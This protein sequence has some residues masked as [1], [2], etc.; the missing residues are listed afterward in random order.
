MRPRGW[1]VWTSLSAAIGACGVRTALH[2]PTDG[3]DGGGWVCPVP[4]AALPLVGAR[5]AVADVDVP[6]P[7]IPNGGY[8]TAEANRQCRQWGWSLFHRGYGLMGCDQWDE[9]PE[10]YCSNI[11]PCGPESYAQSCSRGEVCVSNTPDWRDLKHSRCVE[12]C[13]Q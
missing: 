13:S 5:H 8:C 7:H 4:E 3:S 9:F 6:G 11:Y 12:A 1:F 2:D 10:Y